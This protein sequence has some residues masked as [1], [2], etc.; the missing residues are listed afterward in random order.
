MAKHEIEIH[1][2]PVATTDKVGGDGAP[3]LRRPYRVLAESGL[4]K[5]GKQYDKGD[6]VQLDA[7]TAAGFLRNGEIEDENING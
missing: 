4:F 1:E 2:D 7:L 6:E 3:V 5:N